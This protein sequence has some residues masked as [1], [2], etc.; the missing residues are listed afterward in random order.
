MI[1]KSWK[2]TV[3]SSGG[4]SK[5]TLRRVYLENVMGAYKAYVSVQ[6]HRPHE[7]QKAT[8]PR[9]ILPDHLTTAGDRSNVPVDA[10]LRIAI[11]ISQ[12]REDSPDTLLGDDPVEASQHETNN[13]HIHEL[14]KPIEDIAPQAE[15]HIED[16][17]LAAAEDDLYERESIRNSVDRSISLEPAGRPLALPPSLNLRQYLYQ[18]NIA[19][20]NDDGSPKHA[21]SLQTQQKPSSISKPKPRTPNSKRKRVISAGVISEEHLESLRRRPAA[22]VPELRSREHTKALHKTGEPSERLPDVENTAP[23]ATSYQI[24]NKEIYEALTSPPSPSRLVTEQHTMQMALPYRP[25]PCAS[26]GF[27][28]P[29][30]SN[31][32][33]QQAE[34]VQESIE[35]DDF[36]AQRQAINRILN[37]REASAPVRKREKWREFREEMRRMG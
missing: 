4:V 15:H 29:Q 30:P 9:S 21:E 12:P 27:P 25:S 26:R 5:E 13:Q 35:I 34:I 28:N 7:A 17:L 37:I 19:G 6:A 2:F 31:R 11:R 3:T 1:A 20:P 14:S 32:V 10:K 8:S 33:R 16:E 18:S 36:V 23:T 22:Q 24:D